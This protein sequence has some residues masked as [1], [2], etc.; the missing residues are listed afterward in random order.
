MQNYSFELLINAVIS[1]MIH[2]VAAEAHSEGRVAKGFAE[3]KSGIMFPDPAWMQYG[4]YSSLSAMWRSKKDDLKRRIEL[5]K[6]EAAK[7]LSLDPSRKDKSKLSMDPAEVKRRRII[8]LQRL[9]EKARQDAQCAEMQREEVI[10]RDFYRA[11]L[12]ANLR[13]RRYM[14]EEDRAS[15]N[16]RI[17]EEKAKK[18]EQEAFELLHS[19][20]AVAGATGNAAPGGAGAHAPHLTQAQAAELAAKKE[21]TYER[22]RQEL[23][24]V[25]LERRRRAEDQA[26][27][28]IEDE[29]SKA[30]RELDLLE[31][32]RAAYIAEFG[33]LE[34]E[35]DDDPNATDD[36]KRARKEEAQLEDLGYLER[37]ASSKKQLP[38]PA[39]VRTPPGFEEWPVQKRNAF[40]KMHI[41]VHSKRKRIAKNI[42]REQ[43]MLVHLENKSA[44]DWQ[45]KFSIAALEEMESELALMEAQ[46]E[47]KEAE[48]R[49]IDVKENIQRVMIYCRDKG[50]E[51][52]KSRT[53]LKRREQLARQRD[54][55]L[56]EADA[57]LQLCMR[58]AK[59]RD[60]LKRKV[61]N[62][63][64]WVDTESING[65]HQRFTTELLRERLYLT[66]F[67]QI[68]DSIVN[69]SEIIATERK[70][71]GLQES[72][73][74]NKAHLVTKKKAMKGLLGDI[75][76]EEYMRMK[77]SVL[78]E[79]IFG[80]S[81]RACLQAR[82]GGWVRYFLWCRGNKDAF[83][84][85]YEIIKQQLL[86]DRQ[87]KE[88]LKTKAEQDKQAADLASNLGKPLKNLPIR[89]LMQKHRERT[90][91]C[92]MCLK[93]YLESQNN[94]ILCHYHPK[95]YIMECPATCPNP[96]LTVLCAAH[97]KMR[98]TCCDATKHDAGGCARRY[99]C[100]PE[101]D[102]V[103][104]KIMAKVNERDEDI[105]GSLDEQ[106]AEARKH[107]WTTKKNNAKS[108]MI[109][110]IEDSIQ[111]D[112]ATAQ[113]FKDLKFV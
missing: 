18:A 79:K 55:E 25:T 20:A 47:L 100:P 4:T 107:D 101:V 110:Q 54:Q 7:N 24:E 64:K 52:L 16:M 38:I 106:V 95:Q 23:K 59:N 65:F 8:R 57:W 19:N 105:V 97:R 3:K 26:L 17:A 81:R 61:F 68:V 67:R 93:Y 82:F 32:Q 104:D 86:I 83:K 31:R 98:W 99:H 53:E 66:Y 85:K 15:L 39:Y 28:I 102:P 58:R 27:M 51:E 40:L 71:L 6:A 29:Q 89:T 33:D 48:S 90:V 103:Y 34:G 69:R 14:R 45:G 112:R 10:C 111:K 13:E 56:S 11:E 92:K 43:R 94:S 1:E 9:A 75:R 108:K 87:F 41:L 84:L 46:E 109:F 76:R 77:R 21:F 62:Q 60:K 50:E 12:L 5:G 42:E 113:R 88:Q 35:E 91:Q 96:G 37:M 70:L 80:S 22:R 63:C 2:D 49:L 73:S 36:E 72:L 44:D 74:I 30:L 78:N